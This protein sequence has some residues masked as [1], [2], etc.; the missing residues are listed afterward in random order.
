[1]GSITSPPRVRKGTG[2]AGGAK[3]G[4]GA[5]GAAEARPPIQSKLQ[6]TVLYTREGVSAP[7]HTEARVLAHVRANYSIPDDFELDKVRFGPLS[8]LSYERRLITAYMAGALPLLAGRAHV[9]MCRA[10]GAEGHFPSDCPEAC[11]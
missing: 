10:C 3:A 5:A 9:K 4:V 1:M 7:S 2:V 8:G 11:K 6:E